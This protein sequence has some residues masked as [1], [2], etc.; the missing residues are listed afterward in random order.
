MEKMTCAEVGIN[1]ETAEAVV[2]RLKNMSR[3]EAP[4]QI[5]NLTKNSRRKYANC[6]SECF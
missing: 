3:R 6:F 2:D 4:K 1:I 5:D